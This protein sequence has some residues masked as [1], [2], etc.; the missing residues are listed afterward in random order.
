MTFFYYSNITYFNKKNSHQTLNRL[1]C[2]GID[3]N[4]FNIQLSHRKSVHDKAQSRFLQIDQ[5]DF[6]EHNK[7]Q[8]F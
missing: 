8:T 1:V 5:T 7:I 4:L 2:L 3:K 6:D